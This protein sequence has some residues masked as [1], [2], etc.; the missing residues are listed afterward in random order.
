MNY[1]SL[2]SY[3]DTLFTM[4]KYHQ[5]TVQEVENIYPFERD[6]FIQMIEDYLRK[7]E[8]AQNK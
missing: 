5:Y 2:G 4:K 6:I 1:N 7:L 8:E 3:Y